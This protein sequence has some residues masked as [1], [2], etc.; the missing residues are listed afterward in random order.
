M[1]DRND[2]QPVHRER[3]EA[4][5]SDRDGAPKPD[6]L[7]L[8]QTDVVPK[9]ENA[10]EPLLISQANK[11]ENTYKHVRVVVLD[12]LPPPVI[13]SPS[14]AST[15]MS[16]FGQYWNT[17]AMLGV[18]MFSLL[19]LRSVVNG[20]SGGGN[21]GGAAAG[22]P[23]LTLHT[24]ESKST[25]EG[26]GDAGEDRPRLRLKKGKSVKDDL[27]DIV[28]EDPDAAADILRSWIGK[29]G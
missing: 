16:W 26:A 23:A 3:V 10:V 15:A 25:T 6:D 20:K 14:I 13:E 9:I 1:G 2:S 5:E 24:E 28:R 4:Q 11:L 21:E 17:L 12:S 18:A 27:V 29:A 7:R 19:L 8:V 22:A